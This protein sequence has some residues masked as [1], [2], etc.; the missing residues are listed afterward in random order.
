MAKRKTFE[1]PWRA[2]GVNHPGDFHGTRVLWLD[3][4]HSLVRKASAPVPGRARCCWCG[5]SKRH[6]VVSR[7]PVTTRR[8][9]PA[10][11]EA[12]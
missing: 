7:G 9:R 3:C 10:R 11:K 4:G 5:I 1:P 2:V 6:R 8:I 12:K